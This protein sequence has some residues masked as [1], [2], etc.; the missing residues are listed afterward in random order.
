MRFVLGNRHLLRL[1]HEVTLYAPQL[2]PFADHARRRGLTVHDTLRE[3]P[4]ACDALFAQDS[5]VVYELSQRYLDALCAFRICGDVFDF[6]LPPQVASVVDVIVVLSD[7]YARTAA[8]SAASVPV[9]R[10][11]V[12]IDVDRL[13]SLGAPRERPQ[14]AVVLGNYGERDALVAAAWAGWAS[15][16]AASAA[17]RRVTTSRPASPTRTSSSP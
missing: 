4:S 8:A 5:I 13:V 16:C 10:L 3:L 11:R 6:Q 2:G 12:P 7:R 1:G 9:L 15:M 17:T 14:R